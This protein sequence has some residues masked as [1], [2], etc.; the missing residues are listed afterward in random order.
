MQELYQMVVY[1]DQE[2][3]V[4]MNVLEMKQMIEVLEKAKQFGVQ[5][6]ITRALLSVLTDLSKEQFAV[7]T[8]KAARNL[9]DID[10]MVHRTIV[11]KEFEFRKP[12]EEMKKKWSF[13]ACPL[14]KDP[15]YWISGK[16]TFF[17]S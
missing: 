13:M 11:L 5:N 17:S 15:Q 16:R 8:F 12:E 1:I 2:G 10:L 6:N 3:A 7:M 4:A 14:L 9:N